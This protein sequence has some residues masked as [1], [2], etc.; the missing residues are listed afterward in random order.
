MRDLHSHATRFLLPHAPH[1]EFASDS[2]ANQPQHLVKKF[3]LP[4]FSIP[5]TQ[6][7]FEDIYIY[8]GPRDKYLAVEPVVKYAVE[9]T[10]LP[11]LRQ[12]EV[13]QS[14]LPTL[15]PTWISRLRGTVLVI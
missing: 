11:C 10:Q 1:P 5:L 14:G 8:L 6:C 7:L 12:L 2:W 9:S 3:S 15:V 4:L 13:V